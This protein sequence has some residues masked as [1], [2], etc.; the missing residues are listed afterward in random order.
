MTPEDDIK[1]KAKA[2]PKNGLRD[3]FIHRGPFNG[4]WLASFV[5]IMVENE[6]ERPPRA[7]FSPNWPSC[8]H[9]IPAT[10]DTPEQH[11]PGLENPCQT[12]TPLN[13]N[14]STGS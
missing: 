5:H 13:I 7:V 1:P 2:K 8:C 11:P 4:I 12:D 3:S 6:K 10:T 14:Y 9:S